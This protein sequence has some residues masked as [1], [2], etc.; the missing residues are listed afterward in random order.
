[1]GLLL[2]SGQT[3]TLQTIKVLPNSVNTS[4]IPVSVIRLKAKTKD[5]KRGSKEREYGRRLIS[6][7][8]EGA[9]GGG[10]AAIIIAKE[11]KNW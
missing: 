11:T 9:E 2:A 10:L 1:M 4:G 7:C 5:R 6:D 8:R 3:Y